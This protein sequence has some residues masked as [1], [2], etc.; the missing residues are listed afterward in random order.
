MNSSPGTTEPLT[1]FEAW[2]IA[3]RTHTL[4]AAAVPVLVGAGHAY[5]QGAF[6]T[7]AFLWALVGALAIQIA[8][9]FA[10]D[11]SDAKRGADNEGRIG[12]PRMV[13][14]GAITPRAMWVAT[15][16][17]VAVAAVSAV[18]L[19]IIAGPVI[20]VI[21][22]LSVLAMLGY[23]GGPAPY[24]YRGLG[25]VF[26]FIFFG[27]VA[28]VGSRYVHDMTAPRSI[29]LASV[30]VGLLVTAILVANNYRDIETDAAAGKRTLAVIMGKESTR[31][32][33]AAL[34]YAPFGLL[35]LFV[36]T[37]WL[38]RSVLF[39]GFLLPFATVPV[40]I[41]YAKSEGPALIRALVANA[42][43]HLWFG[44]V[45]AAALAFGGS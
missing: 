44:I 2:R 16:T 4:P 12:P 33:Y 36:V 23:V 21:G 22:V 28:T 39:T 17:A 29:W 34:I 14:S 19:T 38:P 37:G 5:G 30:P 26:V 42:R 40:R 1:S 18:F 9:N 35:V 3:A 25:E 7:D 27:V 24:G 20:L 32:L 45:L 6:R 43:L 13:S 10:N 31:S 8:A 11:A 41:L 15:W